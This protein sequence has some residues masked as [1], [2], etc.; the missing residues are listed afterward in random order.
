MNTR[1]SRL[2]AVA[3]EMSIDERNQWLKDIEYEHGKYGKEYEAVSKAIIQANSMIGV[4][5]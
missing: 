5:K 1:V 4:A 2:V 3:L